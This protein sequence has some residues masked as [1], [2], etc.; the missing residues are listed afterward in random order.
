MSDMPLVLVVDDD[1][2]VRKAL[3]RLLKSAGMQADTFA[4]PA[5]FFEFRLPGVPTC[6]ILD[7]ELPGIDGL[8]LQRKLSQSDSPLP[9]VFISGHGDIPM[10]VR[11]IKSGAVDFLPKP[12]SDDQLLSAVEQ[13]LSRAK[14]ELAARGDV[15]AIRKRLESLSPREREV[16]EHVVSGELNKQIGHRLGVTEKTVKVHRGQVMRKMEAESLADLVRMAEK[17]GI[18]GPSA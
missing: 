6:L 17:V 18:S 12:F 15:R 10:S 1:P 2:S 9:I 3:A 8:E 14:Q 4:S 5:E 11:A 16:L 13:A 7:V